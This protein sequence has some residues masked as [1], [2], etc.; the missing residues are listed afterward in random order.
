MT[1]IVDTAAVHLLCTDYRHR[2]N[3]RKVLWNPGSDHAGIATQAVVERQLQKESGLTRH[4]LGREKFVEKVWKWK[5]EY[6]TV[7]YSI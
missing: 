6:V 1:Q 5:N 7:K 3:G 4:E 2:M